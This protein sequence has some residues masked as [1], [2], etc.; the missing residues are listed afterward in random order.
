MPEQTKSKRII[1][2][3]V[4]LLFPLIALLL[5]ELL[6]RVGGYNKDEHQLFVEAPGQSEYLTINPLFFKRIQ[7]I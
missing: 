1:F 6:L 3:V 4:T 5:I 7:H 2:W